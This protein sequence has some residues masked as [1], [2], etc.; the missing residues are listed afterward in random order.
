M[1]GH[2]CQQIS[3][4]SSTDDVSFQPVLAEHY[5]FTSEHKH[6]TTVSKSGRAC[7]TCACVIL[8]DFSCLLCD[9]NC[10]VVITSSYTYLFYIIV[11]DACI[12][13]YI[14]ICIALIQRIE[15][16]KDTIALLSIC[17]NEG[18]RQC[19]FQSSNRFRILYHSIKEYHFISTQSNV[20]DH[21][22][23]SV[24]ENQYTSIGHCFCEKDTFSTVNGWCGGKTG[25]LKCLWFNFSSLTFVLLDEN[26][27]RN[28]RKLCCYCFCLSV[29]LRS[30]SL[31]KTGTCLWGSGQL[32]GLRA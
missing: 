5:E 7:H 24:Y 26:I 29:R 22:Q 27:Y 28:F 31:N 23:T 8:C 30:K 1:L 9:I 16:R 25:T 12:E 18:F 17:E 19:H 32:V 15:F 4:R 10:F 3:K 11:I 14:S 20:T 6:D 13:L 21:V 2:L